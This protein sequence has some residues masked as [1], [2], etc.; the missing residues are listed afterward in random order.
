[1]KETEMAPRGRGAERHIEEITDLISLPLQDND[2]KKIFFQISTTI[3][4]IECLYLYS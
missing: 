3:M 4:K 1:M 2:D